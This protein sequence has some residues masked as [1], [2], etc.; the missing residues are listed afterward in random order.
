METAE[1]DYKDFTR[2]RAGDERLAVRFFR[3]AK[4][5]PDKTQEAGRPIFDEV[6]YVQ[7]MIPGDRNATNMRPVRP[8]DIQRFQKQY[9][10]WKSTQSNEMVSGTPLEA[11][12]VLSLAQVEEFRYFGVRTIEHMAELRDDVCMKITGALQLKQRAVQ[13]MQIAKDEA[14][15]RKVQ[16]ELDKRDGEIETL[17][18][19]IAEQAQQ[20]KELRA[21]SGAKKE[22]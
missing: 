19:A 12:G 8:G 15:M 21:G 14:P 20:L 5:N 4:Q 16:A 18:Q 13:F 1:Y 11:W 2:P 3:K 10:H 9:E 17:R 7:V 6:D 22:R